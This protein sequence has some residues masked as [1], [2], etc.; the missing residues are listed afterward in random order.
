MA[1]AKVYGL[2]M[3]SFYN[4]EV[5]FATD[6]VKVMLCTSS[7]TPDQDVHRYKSSITNEIP[8]TGGYTARGLT[9]TGKT[10]TYDA[11]S[12]TL[13]LDSADPVWTATTFAAVHYAIFYV[14]TGA[15]GTSPLICYMDFQSD[16]ATT[17][18]DF[19][20]ILPATGIV[21]ATA[22]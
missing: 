11:P 21:Q 4:K 20:I 10:L 17:A 13:T 5:N 14:D 18:Q 8:A 22:A 1:I 15:D 2:G 9:L 7:Y 16:Y 19:T 3:Q 12:N 6:T